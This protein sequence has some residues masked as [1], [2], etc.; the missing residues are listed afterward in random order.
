MLRPLS[1][2]SRLKDLLGVVTR[3]KKKKK[4]AEATELGASSEHLAQTAE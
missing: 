3:V 4:K 1:L 2:S